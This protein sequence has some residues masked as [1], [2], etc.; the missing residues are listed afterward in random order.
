ME[1]TIYDR[2]I[3]KQGLS[4]RVVDIEQTER[5]FNAGELEQLFTYRQPESAAVTE[6]V[7]SMDSVLGRLCTTY[8]SLLAKVVLLLFFCCR[9]K[10]LKRN[11]KK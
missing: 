9:T 8:A 3:A 2:Q 10:E 4:N 5:H 1:N 11:E 6:G 7:G